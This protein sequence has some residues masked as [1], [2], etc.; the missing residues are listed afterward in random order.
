[1]A[2][3]SF[4][5]KIRHL[6]NLCFR[7]VEG[8]EQG[9]DH[10]LGAQGSSNREWSSSGP[11][12]GQSADCRKAAGR[13]A[14]RERTRAPAGCRPASARHSWRASPEG[15][16]KRRVCLLRQQEQGIGAQGI[17]AALP[18]LC[19]R[20]CGSIRASKQLQDCPPGSGS[21]QARQAVNS[22]A[23]VPAVR[24]PG[25]RHRHQLVQEER[26]GQGSEHHHRLRRVGVLGVFDCGEIG[27]EGRLHLRASRTTTCTLSS[28]MASANATGFSPNFPL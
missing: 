20:A 23:P 7:V 27:M 19:F 9:G 25:V 4:Q 26:L 1:M 5:G 8:G 6:S 15:G 14:R 13:P 22:V 24:L 3:Q 28:S 17:L 12:P 16:N 2:R 10:F 21:V 18:H 11:S